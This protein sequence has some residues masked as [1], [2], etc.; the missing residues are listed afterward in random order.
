MSPPIG[1]RARA[2]DA[3]CVASIDDVAAGQPMSAISPIAV[4]VVRGPSTDLDLATDALWQLR[5]DAVEDR[6]TPGG[7]HLV[8]SFGPAGVGDAELEALRVRWHVEVEHVV[9]DSYLDAWRAHATAVRIGRLVLRPAW[10]A[11]LGD[12]RRGREIDAGP[13]GLAD[14]LVV[15]L[16]PGRAF[17]SGAHPTTQG[18]LEVLAGIDLRGARVLDVGCGSG[19][20]SLAAIAFG[21]ESVVAIDLDPAALVATR[22]N[23]QLNAMV[24]RITVSDGTIGSLRAV[25]DVVVANV[26]G[27]VLVALGAEL[28]G[29]VARDGVVVLGGMLHGATAGVEA[30][31]APLVVHDRRHHDGWTTLVLRLP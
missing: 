17:G 22:A 7:F 16:D 19:V 28:V 31:M 15:V 30:A 6:S 3:N 1:R 8:A 20:L 4:L 11:D 21:A 14:E 13:E 9:D 5:P 24:D 26:L 2:S 10:L 27:I 29:A 18:V 23:A 25:F 12:D